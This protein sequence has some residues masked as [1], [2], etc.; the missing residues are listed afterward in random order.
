[1]Q[2][3]NTVLVAMIKSKRDFEIAKSQ[4][5]YRIPKEKAPQFVRENQIKVIAFY[6]T[7]V[8]AEENFSIRY[9]GLVS[10]ILIVNRKELFPK[11]TLNHKSDNEYFKIEFESLLSLKN[12]II[13][14]R[15]IRN[16][17]IP[18]SEEKFFNS[19]HINDIFNGSILED[20]L[21]KRLIEKKIFAERQV[22][23]KGNEGNYYIL[24]FVIYCKHTH[25]NIEC[26]GDAYHMDRSKIQ[27][28][29]NRNNFLESKGWCVLR[30]T[31][32][33]LIKELDKTVS[34]ICETIN[35]Y[36]GVQDEVDLNEY[37]I[38]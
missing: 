32:E 21:W 13:S 7:N 2:N 29:K 18:T 37:R 10:N 12:P 16:V 14:K 30:F 15:E 33:N 11:E 4:L 25:I 31:T 22:Y 5:W 24:D 17:F 6:L 28:D 23:Y 19:A 9:F 1:M 34:L 3:T 27:R 26:D 8:F 20:I 36:G 38:I 35:Y